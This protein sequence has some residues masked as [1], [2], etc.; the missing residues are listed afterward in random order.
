MQDQLGNQRP[1]TQTVNPL[2]MLTRFPNRYFNV[3][4]FSWPVLTGNTPHAP[5]APP[6]YRADSAYRPRLHN[7]N[8]SESARARN[9]QSEA[10]QLTDNVRKRILPYLNGGILLSHTI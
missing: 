2:K 1:I 10:N 8:Q 9:P 7:S 3:T 5:P 4:V 6:H